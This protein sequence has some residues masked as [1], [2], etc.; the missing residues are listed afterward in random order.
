MTHDIIGQSRSVSVDIRRLSARDF[1]SFGVHDIAYIR[2]V[3]MAAGM[4][5]WALHA[6]DGSLLSVQASP[7]LAILAA[8][9]NDMM[10]VSV[11]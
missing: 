5:G 7:E 11:Q 3:S 8:R 4:Q 6:A 2:P 9:Q 1:L 10:A